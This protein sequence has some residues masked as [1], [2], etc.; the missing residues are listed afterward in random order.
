MFL[1]YRISTAAIF[2]LILAL[3]EATSC[4]LPE[5]PESETDSTV[6]KI[7]FIG[8]SYTKYND[9]PRKFELLTLKSGQDTVFFVGDMAKNGH[10]LKMHYFSGE[11]EAEI[12]K[13]EWDYVVLQGATFD[14]PEK[15]SF[16]AYFHALVQSIGAETLLFLPW[17]NRRLWGLSTGV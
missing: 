9:L 5:L 11:A 4:S 7:L 14:G 10:S 1:K 16:A 2:I 17:N 6:K 3:L 8:H 15:Y 12:L 13:Y